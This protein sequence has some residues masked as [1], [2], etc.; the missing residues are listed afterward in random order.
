M[1]SRVKTTRGRLYAGSSGF[2]YP[3]WRDGFYPTDA[4][5]EDFLRLY[6]ERLPSVELNTTFYRLPAEGQFRHW[7]AQ[8][9]PGFRFAVTMTRGATARGRVQGVAAFCQTVRTLGDRLGPIRIKVPQARDDGFLRLLLDSLDPE[10]AVALDFRHGSWDDPDVTARLDDRG[11]VRVDGPSGSAGFRYL[12]LREPP[13]DDAALVRLATEI[14]PVLASGTDVYCY[15]RHEDAPTAP[16]YAE[17][18][19]ELEDAEEGRI[20]GAPAS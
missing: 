6:A 13:Y 2:S 12:R 19:L 14:E 11:V 5:P 17:R 9:A 3:S 18:L 8:T 1:S 4:R 7:A 15:F 20:R 16:G 10:L